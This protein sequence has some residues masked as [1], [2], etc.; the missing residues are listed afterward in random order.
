MYIRVAGPGADPEPGGT[1][2]TEV[3]VKNIFTGLF[4]IILAGNAQAT[5]Q[6]PDI[7]LYQGQAQ[8]LLTNP[9][10][11]YFS[12]RRPKP[13]TLFRFSCTANWRGYVATWEIKEGSLYLVRLTE[14]TCDQDAPEIP[15]AKLFPDRQAPVR[16]DWFSGVLRVPMGNKI[17]YRHMGYMSVYEKD[18]FLTIK[19]GV[20]AGEEIVDNAAGDT[21]VAEPPAER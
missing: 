21:T 12:S 6:V 17:K 16:A 19:S 14:G 9:L 1:L 2:P 11:A 13:D 4:L 3:A 15:L 10:E 8:P 5:A 20:L 7:L 18:R